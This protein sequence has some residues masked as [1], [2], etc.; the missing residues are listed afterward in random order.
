MQQD[1]RSLLIR[2]AVKLLDDGGPGAV[3]LREV[4]SRSGVS[5][6]A[7]YKHFVNK[8]ALLAAI[9]TQELERQSRAMARAASN[10]DP[11]LALRE[12]ARHYIEWA[13]KHPARFKLTF[14]RWTQESPELSEIALRTRSQ[15]V[16]LVRRAQT[17]GDLPPT[18]SGRLAS[19]LQAT[20]H[21][22]ADLALG[23][24]MSA[25]GKGGADPE[26]LV[27]DLLELLRASPAK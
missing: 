12:T 17:S 23:G 25:K 4:A 27:F 26:T 6:N 7:P 14:G 9:A 21:G 20:A 13:L 16:D 1:T 3:T 8:E 11:S 18:N 15:L 10:R 5:H 22:A 19:L 2:E 24:H